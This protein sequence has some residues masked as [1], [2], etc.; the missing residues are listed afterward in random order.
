MKLKMLLDFR[1]LVFFKGDISFRKIISDLGVIIMNILIV[2][3]YFV[4]CMFKY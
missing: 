2:W 4:G 1:Y 3:S